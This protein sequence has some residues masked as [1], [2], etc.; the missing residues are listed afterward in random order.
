MK[1]FAVLALLAAGNAHQNKQQSDGSLVLP[2]HSDQH[3]PQTSLLRQVCTGVG[4]SD[5][6]QLTARQRDVEKWCM[7][8]ELMLQRRVAEPCQQRW[9][10]DQATIEDQLKDRH[11]V[12]RAVHALLPETPLVI[13]LGEHQRMMTVAD[14]ITA[15]RIQHN[16]TD[17]KRRLFAPSTRRPMSILELVDHRHDFGL[18]TLK[19]IFVADTYQLMK[20]YLPQDSFF[21]HLC[22]RHDK[23]KQQKILCSGLELLLKRRQEACENQ[24]T[25]LDEYRAVAS[26]LYAVPGLSDDRKWKEHR[27]I[28][29]ALEQVPNKPGIQGQCRNKKNGIG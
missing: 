17:C 5:S 10:Y 15:Q 19:A 12:A 26:L 27:V 9:P 23:N 21:V 2:P 11:V 16:E 1:I 18:K 20:A 25:P 14:K 24:V 7:G 22:A 29:M 6:G 13:K 4:V 8:L 28:M 3:M